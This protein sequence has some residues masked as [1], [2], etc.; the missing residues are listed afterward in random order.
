M[1]LR[2][3]QAAPPSHEM[4]I[5]PALHHC[6]VVALCLHCWFVEAQSNP[7]SNPLVLWLNS[8]PG[9]SPMEGFLKEHGPPLPGPA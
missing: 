2:L 8:S 9:C 1:L 6:R 4:S 3:D 7:Q 5:Q